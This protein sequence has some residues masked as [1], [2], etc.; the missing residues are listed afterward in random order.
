MISRNCSS[1]E[2]TNKEIGMNIVLRQTRP[3]F[4][5]AAGA[6]N[7]QGGVEIGQRDRRQSQIAHEFAVLITANRYGYGV[8]HALGAAFAAIAG[9]IGERAA[10]GIACKVSHN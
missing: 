7:R 1:E 10:V 9:K 4:G 2:A 6:F 8:R 5:I 3:L